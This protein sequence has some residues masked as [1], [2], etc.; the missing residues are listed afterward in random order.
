MSNIHVFRV[1][2]SVS[3]SVF[4]WLC[5][6]GHGVALCFRNTSGIQINVCTCDSGV[7]V[8]CVKRIV[9]SPPP[10]CAVATSVHL[11]HC[12]CFE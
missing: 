2:V 5:E 4:E 6:C 7:F 8:E 10:A 3:E 1:S 11:I 12:F 9:T